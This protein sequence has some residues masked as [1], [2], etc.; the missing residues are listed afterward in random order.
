METTCTNVTCTLRGEVMLGTRCP[1][2]DQATSPIERYVNNEALFGP[3]PR[4]R[5]KRADQLRWAV[6]IVLVF[7]FFSVSQGFR[8]TVRSAITSSSSGCSVGPPARQLFNSGQPPME[9]VAIWSNTSNTAAN[10]FI[11]T[12][13]GCFTATYSESGMTDITGL[14]SSSDFGL[15][16]FW[17][18]ASEHQI[19]GVT[20][21]FENSGLFTKVSFMRA[22]RCPVN[23][24]LS[25]GSC[26]RK[27]GA[28]WEYETAAG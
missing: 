25:L 15:E 21:D 18:D 26:V 19:N 16:A 6:V 8:P 2:C 10:N 11:K 9:I 7:L 20:R 4:P 24:V 14:P 3:K 5:T 13:R 28:F 27:G 12:Y 1:A 22:P 23:A 17:A